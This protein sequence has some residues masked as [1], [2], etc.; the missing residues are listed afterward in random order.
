MNNLNINQEDILLKKTILSKAKQQLKLEFVGLDS[1]IDEI[2]D[3][4]LPWWLFPQFQ[5]R[6][7]IINLWGMTGTGKTALIKRLME[8][9]SLKEKLLHFDMGTFG[10]GETSLKDTFTDDLEHFNAQEVVLAFDEFQFARSINEDGD[11]VNNHKLRIIWDLLDSGQFTYEPYLNMYYQ[12]KVFHFLKILNQAQEGGVRVKNVLIINELGSFKQLIGD[13]TL[14][15]KSSDDKERKPDEYFVSDHFLD[16]IDDLIEGYFD[17]KKYLE[18]IKLMS[19]EDYIDFFINL[20]KQKGK[21]GLMDM[22]KALIFVVGNL[23]EAFYMSDSINPDISADEFHNHSK[24]I[25]IAS[26]KSALQERFRNEQI[27]RLGN[28]H[29]IYPSFSKNQYKQLIIKGLEAVKKNIAETFSIEIHFNES[30]ID[31]IYTEGVFPTQGARPVLTTLR[32]LIDSYTGKWILEIFENNLF[33]TDIH[34][35]YQNNQYLLEFWN[36][37]EKILEQQYKLNLKINP[38]RQTRNNDV[39]AYVAIHEAGHAVLSALCLKLIPEYVVTQ[40]ADSNSEGFCLTNYPDGFHTKDLILNRIKVS[41]GGYLAEKLILGEDFV[42]SGVSEDIAKATQFA[43][44]AV[45][46]FAMGKDPILSQHNPTQHQAVFTM[47]NSQ[48]SQSLQI[49][50]ECE[51]EALEILERNELL[52]LKLTEYLT[53][54]SRIEK[55]MIQKIVEEFSVEPFVKEDGFKDIKHYYNIKNQVQKRMLQLEFIEE[56]EIG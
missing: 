18:Q 39:Q 5:H 32:N 54:N 52:L 4:M 17:K 28:N 26:I 19:L 21:Q 3:L 34:W 49:I 31:L 23:D 36:K 20:V 25:T 27:A 47:T 37:S 48:S 14:S 30:V 50:K 42:S 9:M 55:E 2:A 12:N 10:D 56:F 46:R 1:I 40:T 29:I 44:D 22:S 7:T 11:E 43:N 41:L 35:S 53:L 8:L 6:P 13:F 24:K 45:N 51:T 33:V 15:S 38:L 16:G